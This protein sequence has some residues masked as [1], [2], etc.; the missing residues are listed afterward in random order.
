MRWRAG[1]K[2]L[3]LFLFFLAGCGV[4]HKVYWGDWEAWQP[5]KDSGGTEVRQLNISSEPYEAEVYINNTFYG[6]TPIN[7][8]LHYPVIV[9]ERKKYKYKEVTS[10]RTFMYGM[11]GTGEKPGSR[12]AIGSETDTMAS[13]EN[14]SHNVTVKKKGYVSCSQSVSK[15]DT[16]VFFELERQLCL[17]FDE[18]KV[19]NS[20]KLGVTQWIH[21]LLFKDR[22]KKEVT[23]AKLK[24]YFKNNKNC[25][26]LFVYSKEQTGCY[27]LSCF[28]II[29]NDNSI[30][31]TNLR[32]PERTIVV[33]DSV[34]FS[35]GR[36]TD[37]FL[38]NLENRIGSESSKIYYM[39]K[40]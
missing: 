16:S 9:S 36:E 22:F 24:K 20:I 5:G 27:S 13:I 32:S 14:I 26:D 12:R 21:D 30:L 38:E 17:F 35:T 25:K 15:H 19:E 11:F 37:D 8:S 34:R 2:I 3:F 10:N 29:R 1:N 33:D 40:K 4:S 7:V 18:F 6:T 23:P 28:L 39:L 31:T